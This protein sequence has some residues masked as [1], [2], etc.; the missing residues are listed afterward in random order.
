MSQRKGDIINTDDGPRE[1]GNTRGRKRPDTRIPL[2]LPRYL[3]DLIREDA[4]ARGEETGYV[5][6]EILHDHYGL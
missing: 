4:V 5:I 6:R 2:G 1:K 3:H